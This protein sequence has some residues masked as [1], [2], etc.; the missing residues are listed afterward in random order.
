[1]K[2]TSSIIAAASLLLSS[3]T[4]A[5]V[6][7]FDIGLPKSFKHPRFNGN[8][9]LGQMLDGKLAGFGF[10]RGTNCELNSV[11]AFGYE[12]FQPGNIYLF[13]PRLYRSKFNGVPDE[14]GANPYYFS[15]L[16]IERG[17]YK[18]NWELTENPWGKTSLPE[19]GPSKYGNIVVDKMGINIGDGRVMV[20]WWEDGKGYVE[21]LM[22]DKNTGAAFVQKDGRVPAGMENIGQPVYAFEKNGRQVIPK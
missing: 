7:V 6:P 5:Q 21:F 9:C 15:R 2:L 19:D 18:L 14:I 11:Y 4:N 20:T 8:Y 3:V 10:G 22:M 17:T 1:M 13:R 12:R 16:T